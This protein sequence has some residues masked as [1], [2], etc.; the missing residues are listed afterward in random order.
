[1]ARSV[2]KGPFVHHSLLKKIDKLKDAPNKK[3]IKTW[4]RRS[5]NGSRVISRGSPRPRRLTT[6]EATDL[7]RGALSCGED[8]DDLLLVQVQ[9][10]EHIGDSQ[11]CLPRSTEGL[12]LEV[13]GAELEVVTDV[14]LDRCN[15]RE[16]HPVP[17]DTS[18]V[19]E[20]PERV[21]FRELIHQRLERVVFRLV[22]H[23]W[24]PNTVL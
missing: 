15:V 4:S 20:E 21:T 13:G 3:P 6:G 18:E 1:M 7:V 5:M 9:T 2:W 22:D 19:T 24:S 12:D 8:Q 23:E 11:I 17:Y 14:R 10:P 16:A